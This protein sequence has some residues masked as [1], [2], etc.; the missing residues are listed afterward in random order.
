VLERSAADVPELAAVFYG[1]VRR[2]LLDRLAQ[3]TSKR[4]ATGH[5]RRTDPKLVARLLVETVTTFA[6]HIYRDP[7]PEPPPFD[8]ADAPPAVIG[9]LVAGVVIARR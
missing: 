6:R 7:D 1:K 5:Y 3:L 4:M 2:G 8:L 9:I